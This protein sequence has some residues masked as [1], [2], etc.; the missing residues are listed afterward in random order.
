MSSGVVFFLFII[1][2]LAALCFMA[3]CPDMS[4]RISAEPSVSW[5]S[6]EDSMF[7]ILLH[8]GKPYLLRTNT[9][10]QLSFNRFKSTLNKQI[11][12]CVRFIRY[13]FYPLIE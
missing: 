7:G 5:L 12:P 9:Q 3:S 8:Q 10:Q 11:R 4:S 6:W 13:I 1:Y 2:I